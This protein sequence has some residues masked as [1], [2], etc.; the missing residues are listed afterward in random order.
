MVLNGQN[1][2]LFSRPRQKLGERTDEPFPCLGS[3]STEQS[4]P[5]IYTNH[6]RTYRARDLDPFSGSAEPLPPTA[7]LLQIGEVIFGGNGRDGYTR[8]LAGFAETTDV[9]MVRPDVAKRQ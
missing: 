5:G 3:L 4:S 7:L 6:T 1:D 9:R 2:A 8:L